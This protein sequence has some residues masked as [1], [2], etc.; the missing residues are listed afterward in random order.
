MPRRREA[1]SV[2][3]DS[4][5]ALLS[6][7]MISAP[8]YFQT[9]LSFAATVNA[10]FWWASTARSY[11]NLGARRGFTRLGFLWVDERELSLEK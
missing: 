7:F 5:V 4:L 1:V 10:T 9:P 2:T 6:I 11:Y 3:V 8:N